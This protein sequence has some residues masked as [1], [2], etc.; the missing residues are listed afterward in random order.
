MNVMGQRANN[1]SIRYNF[2]IACVLNQSTGTMAQHTNQKF[3]RAPGF[4]AP[5]NE[6]VFS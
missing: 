5:K 3:K 6:Q 2:A 4:T 1:D